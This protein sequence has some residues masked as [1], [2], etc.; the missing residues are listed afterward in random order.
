MLLTS[1]GLINTLYYIHYTPPIFSRDYNTA[2]G[3]GFQR[4]SFFTPSCFL[5]LRRVG[6]KVGAFFPYPVI[7]NPAERFSQQHPSCPLLDSSLFNKENGCTSYTQLVPNDI[8]KRIE[9]GTEKFKKMYNMRTGS[10]RIFS[11]LLSLCMN[12]PGVKRT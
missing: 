9:Y 5:P 7:I 11:R 4:F 1:T 6:Y 3:V 10:E 12:N 8:K 2:S